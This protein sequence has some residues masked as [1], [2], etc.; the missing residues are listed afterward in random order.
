MNVMLQDQRRNREWRAAKTNGLGLAALAPPL[1]EEVGQGAVLVDI[2]AL[3]GEEMDVVRRHCQEAECVL[4]MTSST[5]PEKLQRFLQLGLDGIIPA[6]AGAQ[7][8]ECA[9]ASARYQ[10]K[11]SRGL[12][13]RVEEL[14]RKLE[15]RILIER[16]KGVIAS[17]ARIGE[18]EALRRLRR[19][20]RN[21]RRSM[22]EIAQRLL[23]AER[24]LKADL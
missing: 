10:A 13:Q 21:Q 15:D 6:G 14:E 23:E 4:G 16:A 3:S 19:E 8:I 11:K 17:R 12:T 22:R 1:M 20:A 2:D 9:L 24:M 7:E 5:E 18:E